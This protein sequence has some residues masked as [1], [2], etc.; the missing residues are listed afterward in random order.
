[1]AVFHELKNS[2]WKKSPNR[3]RHVKNSWFLSTI[4]ILD[5]NSEVYGGVGDFANFYDFKQ[6]K[7]LTFLILLCNPSRI[8]DETYRSPKS[9]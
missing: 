9:S 6:K 5:E 1:M 8:L 7:Y 4:R 3:L 2:L